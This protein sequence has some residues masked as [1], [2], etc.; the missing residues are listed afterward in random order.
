MCNSLNRKMQGKKS[1]LMKHKDLTNYFLAKLRLYKYRINVNITI[2]FPN[3]NSCLDGNSILNDVKNKIT[4]PLDILHAEFVKYFPFEDIDVLMK[5]M[6]FSLLCQ[7]VHN[8]K[9]WEPLT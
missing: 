6:S 9:V 7:V 4:N 8:K 2:M 1:N 3:M 5:T